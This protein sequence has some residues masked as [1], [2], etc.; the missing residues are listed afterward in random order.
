MQSSKVGEKMKLDKK[1][2]EKLDSICKIAE[3]MP[4][5]NRDFLQNCI[6]RIV[7]SIK[8]SNEEELKKSKE[9]MVK[10]CEK[11]PSKESMSL[12]ICLLM[13]FNV[14]SRNVLRVVNEEDL[15]N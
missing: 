10:F 4:K 11:N 15:R 2:I 8:S 7:I 13:F 12:L 1:A 3:S 5:K 9:E 6:N 14:P